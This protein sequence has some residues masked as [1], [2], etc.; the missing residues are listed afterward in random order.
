MC[1]NY[2][3]PNLCFKMCIFTINLAAFIILT[4]KTILFH[5]KLLL[6]AVIKVTAEKPFKYYNTHD[7]NDIVVP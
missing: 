2:L 5:K 4:T 3:F 1:L 6:K 7:N